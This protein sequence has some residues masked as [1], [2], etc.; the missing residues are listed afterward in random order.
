M[1]HALLRQCRSRPHLHLQE[2]CPPLH[3][4]EP[5][6]VEAAARKLLA[7]DPRAPACMDGPGGASRE[8][9][10]EEA[11]RAGAL[12]RVG[13][14]FFEADA[15]LLRRPRVARSVNETLALLGSRPNKAPS[16]LLT[17]WA[18]QHCSPQSTS[19]DVW[20]RA[21]AM[22]QTWCSD[23]GFQACRARGFKAR[24][25]AMCSGW[26][27]AYAT[28]K[29]DGGEELAACGCCARE[30]ELRLVQAM[31]AGQKLDALTATWQVRDA[32][33]G[34]KLQPSCVRR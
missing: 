6:A 10:A 25:S 9:A 29:G 7:A 28:D 33:R 24:A 34:H 19:L 8:E 31:W 26:V 17:R 18:T 3:Q 1:A 30:E 15:A 2:V 4:V 11:W 14:L 12:G 16:P 23:M 5:G 22:S 27:C 21:G 13:A 32:Q 20:G